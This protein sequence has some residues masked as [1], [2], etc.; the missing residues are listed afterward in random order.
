MIS[1]IDEMPTVLRIQKGNLLSNCSD[2]YGKTERR[3]WNMEI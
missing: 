2:E 3:F 1:G